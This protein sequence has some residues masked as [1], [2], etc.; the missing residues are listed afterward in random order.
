MSGRSLIAL[1]RTPVI[2][3]LAFMHRLATPQPKGAASS[4]TPAARGRLGQ[5]R[6]MCL[7]A[8]T[9]ASP[10]PMPR[11]ARVRA[12][13]RECW[14]L[15]ELARQVTVAPREIGRRL[16]EVAMAACDAASAGVQVLEAGRFRWEALA[17]THARYQSR[18]TAAPMSPSA[19]CVE[20]GRSHVI[21]GLARAYPELAFDPPV[22]EAM[23]V[24]F[25]MRSRPVGAVWIMTDRNDRHFEEEDERM[26]RVLADFASVCW[27]EWRLSA[28]TLAEN[29]RRNEIFGM[30]AH[31]LRNPL[32]A[33]SAAVCVIERTPVSSNV[34]GRQA[35]D[36]AARQSRVMSRVIEDLN[37]LSRIDKDKLE[38][39]LEVVELQ[40]VVAD[41]VLAARPRL[42]ARTQTL[43]IVMPRQT[44]RCRVD[45][46]RL[47]QILSNLLDNA[48]K[49]T[50]DGGHIHLEVAL[51]RHTVELAVRDD[52]VG[53]PAD[54]LREIFQ[55]FT[56]LRSPVVRTA[57]GLGLGLALADKLTRMLGGSIRA[58]SDG[59]GKGAEFIVSFPMAKT[60]LDA[61]A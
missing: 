42:E 51:R 26:L 19:L 33:I 34:D 18:L 60:A 31:E 1:L 21:R 36:I 29:R 49:Y 57:E 46:V 44:I 32:A 59:P 43:Q 16:A 48:S 5:T 17:G 6:A 25:P 10:R 23:L 20:D 8:S 2:G 54:K 61:I 7:S 37:D 14:A 27:E 53:I 50:P 28:A 15:A 4:P 56:Q 52:G 47:M 40:A 58:A 45:S 35:L 9:V 13:E 22:S 39:R 12:R 3:V 30:V 11:S 55:P 41:V 24:P 38:L